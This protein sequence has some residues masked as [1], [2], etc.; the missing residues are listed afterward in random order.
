M[1]TRF[2]AATL[3]LGLAAF[4]AARGGAEEFR[5]V[6]VS[7]QAGLTAPTWGGGPAKDHILESVGTGV[8]VVDLDGDGLLDLYVVNAWRL[9][10]SPSA[11]AERGRNRL[12]RNL[13]DWRFEE[14]PDAGGAADT[15]WGCGVCAGDWDGDGLVDLYV[16]NFG[17]NRLYRNLGGMRFEDVSESAGVTD[18]GWGAGCAFLDG[19]GDGDL[20]LYVANYL[21]CT[22]EEVLGARRTNRWR[23]RLDVM[24]GPFGMRG[25]RDVYYRNDGSH[26]TDATVAAGL[27]DVA[28]AYGLGVLVSDLDDD[29]D[30]DL[31]VAND[32]NANYLYSNRGG[33]E[34][35]ET[36]AWSGAGFS[37]EGVA[38]AG[39]GVD[40][41][42]FDGDLRFDLVVTNF[43]RDH[44]T[45]YHNEG[46]GFFED[47]SGPWGLKEPTNALLSWGCA[48]FDA[49]LDA[50]PDLLIVSG[51][52][53]PQVA[54]EPELDESY[55]Q[56]LLLLR[57][58]GDRFADVSAAAGSGLGEFP[59]RGL[60]LGD[61]D[62][63][64]DVDAVVSGMDVPPRLL[65]N[66]SERKGHW[67][68][69]RIR[70]AAG[71]PAIHA[72]AEVTAGGR[73]QI[74][75]VRSGSTYQSQSS[76]DM[77]F[78][79]GDASTVE[80]LAV[81]WPDG[82]TRVLENVAADRLVVVEPE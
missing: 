20:D 60:A 3:V 76:F 25:G 66:D 17:P 10:E 29:G 7:A 72:R 53:Y 75:E 40:A 34:F 4:P 57:N 9:T 39:M 2:L 28:E 24:A 68:E 19:D 43:A 48:F 35:V 36:G 44:C 30:P 54:E 11:I 16:S 62:G 15:S 46:D 47:V 78:G 45:L 22:V 23:E 37:G 49:D 52:I 12:Y 8:A 41:G 59:S 27:E 38:Q 58:D 51:H 67:L 50:D 81:R 70:D 31:Y 77:H 64:G 71:A 42:D 61:L 56:P 18:A 79:L 5:F 65:R 55:A 74:G 26:F 33:G 80:R 32:S 82:S 21:D 63:D 1:R 69:V 13:G 73:T 14:V 6:D